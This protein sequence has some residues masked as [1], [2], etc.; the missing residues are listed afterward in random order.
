MASKAIEA[1]AKSGQSARNTI[2]RM[3]ETTRV[4]EERVY[5][6]AEVA[7]GGLIGGFVDGYWQKP[8]IMG[9]P[10]TPAIGA[11]AALLGL[12][13]YVPGGMH[14]AAVGI[15]MV[16]GPLYEFAQRKGAEVAAG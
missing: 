7:G 12:S 15:G 5:T 9:V 2:A 10:A 14:L 13:G 4:Q 3:K 16:T 6:V 1:L 8:E 11:V